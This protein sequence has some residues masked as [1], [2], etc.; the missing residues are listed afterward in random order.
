VGKKGVRFRVSGR[1]GETPI[2]IKKFGVMSLASLRLISMQ[3]RKRGNW[4]ADV[5]GI[6]VKPSGRAY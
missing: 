5:I 1:P 2:N 4:K 3:A 6:R